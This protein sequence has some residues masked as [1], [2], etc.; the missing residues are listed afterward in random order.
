MLD[1]QHGNSTWKLNTPPCRRP[2][3]SQRCQS[4][5][6]YGTA[7]RSSEHT[8]PH[9]QCASEA[10]PKCWGGGVGGGLPGGWQKKG[11]GKVYTENDLTR[12]RCP[13][14]LGGRLAVLLG[15]LLQTGV[16]KELG[17]PRLGPG[18]VVRAEGRVSLEEDSLLVA[19]VFEVL[20]VQVGVALILNGGGYR[21]AAV[22]NLGQLAVVKV[23]DADG[24]VGGLRFRECRLRGVQGGWRL[25][26]AQ[27]HIVNMCAGVDGDQR[28]R[29][30][31]AFG[32]LGDGRRRRPPLTL[33]GRGPPRPAS[34]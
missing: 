23:G 6:R 27:G 25:R 28:W 7:S 26:G 15:H 10:P 33:T 16:L 19:K 17:I 4:S 31:W 11:S 9:A 1:K 22:A 12:P 24:A 20:L 29:H 32:F 21:L 18:A 8:T 5:P 2:A 13:T 3:E 14:N 30:S 34:P